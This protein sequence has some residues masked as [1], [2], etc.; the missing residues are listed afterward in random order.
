MNTL[1]KV[2]HVAERKAME[3]VIDHIVKGLDKD[4]TGEYL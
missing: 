2:S 4:R 1:N 3:V